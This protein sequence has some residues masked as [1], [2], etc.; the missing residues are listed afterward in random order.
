MKPVNNSK[1]KINGVWYIDVN[2]S[3]DG[4]PVLLKI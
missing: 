1:V 4:K 3:V 2:C